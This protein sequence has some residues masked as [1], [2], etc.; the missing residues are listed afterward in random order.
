MVFVVVVVVVVVVIVVVDVVLVEEP[1][2]NMPSA[3][4]KQNISN[5]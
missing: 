2:G 4:L 1:S 3:L 5:S